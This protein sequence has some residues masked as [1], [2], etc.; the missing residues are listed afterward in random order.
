MKLRVLSDT[1]LE[2]YENY[3]TIIAKVNCTFGEIDP[4]EVLILP[5][6]LGMVCDEE[7][8]FNPELEKFLRFLRAKWQYII[9]VPGNTEYHGIT[10]FSSLEKTEELLKKK[11]EEL[12][13]FYLQKNVMM[14]DDVYVIGCTLWKYA[15]LK[16]W[17]KLPEEDRKIFSVSE[18]YNT[19]YVDHLEWINNI[20]AEIKATGKKAIIIT[21]YPPITTYKGLMFKWE[22][23]D[24][25][26][27][28]STHIEHFIWCHRDTIKTWICGHIHDK[29]Y[30][31]IATVPVYL[32]SMG[33][34]DENY[35]L[36]K[37]LINLN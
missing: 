28:K 20:L 18:N 14:I 31:E 5:G 21:H 11:C 23:D 6:D 30:M 13:I 12:N 22:D 4:N 15:T 34:A 10:D 19:Q 37:G 1:H 32:N 9:I 35:K 16:E 25:V 36:Q 27:H 3:N 29:S 7:G 2:G 8:I 17:N 24:G 26:E 33:E